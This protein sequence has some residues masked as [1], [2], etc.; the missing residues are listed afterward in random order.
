VAFFLRS[1]LRLESEEGEL[2]LL[3]LRL[4]AGLGGLAEEAG[5]LAEEEMALVAT[6]LTL[7]E[8]DGLLRLAWLVCLAGRAGER[9]RC[10]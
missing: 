2:R 6:D 8:A 10:G 1:R 9:L 3:V 4:L 5:L 7:C